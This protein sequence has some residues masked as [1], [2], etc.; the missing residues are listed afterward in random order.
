MGISKP[1]D[2]TEV[3]PPKVS[4]FMAKIFKKRLE[5]AY[6]AATKLTKKNGEKTGQITVFNKNSYNEKYTKTAIKRHRLVV[7]AKWPTRKTAQI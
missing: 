1:S 6:Y 2:G 3:P 5:Y 7:F 4:F